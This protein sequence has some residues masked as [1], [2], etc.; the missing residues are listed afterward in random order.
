MRSISLRHALSSSGVTVA[1]SAGVIDHARQR[2]RLERK[3]LRLDGPLERHVARRHRPLLDAEERL[4]GRAIEDEQQA[5]LA[6]H[7]HRGDGPAAL[8]TSISTGGAERSASQM[9]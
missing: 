4:A 2:R 3:R 1:M 5:D 7:G 9:S 6:D 8:S